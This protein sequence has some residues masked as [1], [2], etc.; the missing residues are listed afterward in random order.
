MTIKLFLSKCIKYIRNKTLEGV[1][2]RN[3]INNSSVIEQK[4]LNYLLI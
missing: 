2:Y 3:I 1:N 4:Y